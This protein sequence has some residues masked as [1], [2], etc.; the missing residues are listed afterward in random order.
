MEGDTRHH[1][2]A[3]CTIGA[4]HPVD[5]DGPDFRQVLSLRSAGGPK[6]SP[7]GGTVFY[8]V[9]TTDWEAN[10]YDREIWL[11]RKGEEPFQL[12]R[13]DGKDSSNPRWSPDGRRVAFV[14]DRGNDRQ[15][16]L[17]PPN[18][19]EAR[20]LTAVVDGVSSFEWSP[21]GIRLAV[22]ITEPQEKNRKQLEESYGEAFRSLNVRN[23]GVGDAW[24]VISGIDHLIEQ[25][26]V[27]PD[28]MGAMGWS[29]GGYIS[30]FLTT[31]SDR[32]RGISVGAGWVYPRLRL[33]SLHGWVS[34]HDLVAADRSQSAIGP[35][36][37]SAHVTK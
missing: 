11:A 20:P 7:D 2:D 4:L 19:G 32:F 27:D 29:Q 33:P 9:T 37:L 23:L 3:T 10:R 35:L 31:T 36:A 13:T 16:W 22:A 8:T 6:V 30:A 5:S 12:T 28:D 24:D 26:Y 17:I 15:I 21:D 25:G 14:A 1:H 18:G 34:L